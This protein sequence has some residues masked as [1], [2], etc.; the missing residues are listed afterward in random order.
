MASFDGSTRWSARLRSH[1]ALVAMV[2]VMLTLTLGLAACG[3]NE[4]G[5]TAA[6]SGG[7][8]SVVIYGIADAV[9]ITAD[10]NGQFNN[11]YSYINVYETL[12]RYDEATRKPTPWLATSWDVSPD[13]LTWTFHLR[14]GVKFQ[15]GT[16]FDAAAAKFSLESSI[17]GMG[18]WLFPTTESIE[19]VDASTL[20]FHLNGPMPIAEVL[21][22]PFCAFMVSPTA[23][24]KFGEKAFEPGNGAGTGPYTLK[25]VNTTTEATLERNPDYWGGWEGTHSNAPQFAIIRQISEPAVRA[26]NLERNEVQVIAPVPFTEIDR[27]KTSGAYGVSASWSSSYF[28]VKFNCKEAPLS[29]VNLRA[30][31]WYAYPFQQVC[32]LAYGGYAKPALGWISPIVYGYDQQQAQIAV[33]VQDLTKAKEFL[34]KSTHPDGGVTLVCRVDAANA[35][36][37]K[38]ME[39]YKVELAKLGITLD[40]QPVM[41]DV[42]NNEAALDDPP[43][44]LFVCSVSPAYPNAVATME[45]DV[46][47]WMVGITNQSY[48]SDPQ[49][50]KLVQD[51]YVA[52]ATDATGVP[53]LVIEATKIVQ[54]GYPVI[55]CAD[56][57]LVAAASTK[58][59]GFE[60]F[61][62]GYPYL[63]FFYDV[64]ME[65]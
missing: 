28:Q 35:T 10:P 14:Q 27:L 12:T 58:L 53:A 51:A 30:A 47:S 16:A 20:V 24:Q 52:S 2:A 5:T 59:K 7:E 39:L 18:G 65:E 17:N 40:V 63:V 43:Q 62:A 54:Q 13:G 37:Q 49:V 60:G 33:P 64:W 1:M 8:P 15:D 42:M 6:T 22:S 21:S 38:A 11:P 44:D 56:E 31:M 34:A 3:E 46:A 48:W 55:Q 61:K 41:M 26:Q 9:Q 57:Q 36:A 19:A 25:A 4:T 50:D 29:D 23:V 32:D 45:S